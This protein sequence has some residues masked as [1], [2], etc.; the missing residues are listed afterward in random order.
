MIAPLAI[1]P[2]SLT[3]SVPAIEQGAV[4]VTPASGSFA[5]VIAAN[6]NAR[7]FLVTPGEYRGWGME[8]LRG[9]HGAAEAPYVFRYEHADAATHPVK[10]TN[11]ALVNPIH[12]QDSEHVVVQGMTARAPTTHWHVEGNPEFGAS[13]HIVFDRMLTEGQDHPYCYRILGSHATVQNSVMRDGIK[14]R[15]DYVGIQMKPFGLT[16]LEHISVINN[17][18]WNIKDFVGCTQS[19]E[20][21]LVTISDLVIENNDSYNTPDY[22]GATENAIDIKVRPEAGRRNRISRNRL[23]NHW[24]TSAEWG[25]SAAGDA[26]VL[27]RLCADID[28]VDNIIGECATGIREEI[29]PTPYGETFDTRG[30]VIK[31]NYLHDIR[32]GGKFEGGALDLIHTADV[33]ENWFVRCGYVLGGAT[34]LGYRKGGPTFERNVRVES[35]HL[36]APAGDNGDRHPIPYLPG[37]NSDHIGAHAFSYYRRQWTGPELVTVKSAAREPRR[38]SPPFAAA[39]VRSSLATKAGR[40]AKWRRR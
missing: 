8:F 37:K 36:R 35:P 2:S 11:H 31:R 30:L 38:Y 9:L 23:W 7:H 12:F 29:Y 4:T 32:G 34:V 18:C 14:R 26:I 20:D 33:S 22:F 17:E 5:A 1:T 28:V 39:P 19:G 3:R 24:E 15:G 27:H 6:S 10:R 13:S 21:D 40:P 25:A 16:P